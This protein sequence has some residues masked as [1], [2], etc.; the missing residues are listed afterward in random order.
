[1]KAI[2]SSILLT[3]L[4]ASAARADGV[5]RAGAN[6]G[7]PLGI[8]SV[9]IKLQ[10]V[11]D[12]NDAAV[13]RTTH[14]TITDVEEGMISEYGMMGHYRAVYAGLHS[15]DDYAE[16][17]TVGPFTS[18]RGRSSSQRW[19]QDENGITNVVQDTVR[20]E[21]NSVL[22]F[23]NDTEN[24]KND[25]VLL[26]EITAPEDDYVVQVK[27]KNLIPFWSFYNKKSGLLDRVEEGYSDSRVVYTYDDYR[28]AN[29][30]KE[31]WHTHRSDGN[32]SN[33]LDMRITSDKYGAPVASGDFAIPQTRADFVHFPAGK[34]EV[35]MPSDVSIEPYYNITFAD[36]L[37][38]VNINGRGL[39]MLL[40]SSVNDIVL[41]DEVAKEL[42]LQTYGPYEKD[43]KGHYYPTRSII[44]SLSIGDLTMQNVVVSC[45]HENRFERNGA[46]AV[47]RIGFDFLANAVVAI[48]Y[49]NKKVK[50]FDPVQF[51]PPADSIPT[52]V[53]VDDGIPFVSAQ[54]GNAFGDHFLLDTTAPATVLLPTFWQAH[55]D[56]VKDQRGGSP[57]SSR[58]FKDSDVQSTQLQSFVFG[59]VRFNDF[60]VY[61]V[62]DN[63]FYEGIDADGVI[64]YNFLRYFN[65]FFDYPHHQVYLEQNAD[66]RRGQGH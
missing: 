59:G 34:T 57:L 35:D 36:P 31:A 8:A 16:T 27:R 65:V 9:S 38:R 46:K 53:N 12:A 49:V 4:I 26:G 52:P 47:G 56:D 21:E 29:G 28:L 39:D 23:I 1:M 18:R 48:D 64:G 25:V 33:D 54:I 13:G 51:T 14:K 66:F 37:I 20:A 40:D 43:D 11:L 19:R 58:S 55:A 10:S 17:T 3:L 7:P 42:G 45:R 41:D 15:G 63:S 6:D 5:G 44:A 62:A 61:A 30:V 50:A 2:I 60:T 22:G 32:S 24:P